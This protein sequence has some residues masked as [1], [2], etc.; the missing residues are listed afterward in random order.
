MPDLL[1]IFFWGAL[2]TGAVVEFLLPFRAVGA[3]CNRRWI[4]NFAL[5]GCSMLCGRWLL[6]LIVALAASQLDFGLLNRLRSPVLALLCGFLILD[7]LNYGLHRLSHQVPLLWRLHR[8]HHSD[9]DVD[10]STSFRHHPL[11]TAVTL[12]VISSAIIAFG[13]PP[14][15]V[16]AHR[17]GRA[18]TDVFSHLN[19]ALPPRLDRLLRLVIITPAMHRIHHSSRQVETDSNYSTLLSLWDR[20]F[21]SYRAAPGDDPRVMPLGL[22]EWRDERDLSLPRLLVQPFTTPAPAPPPAA[23]LARKL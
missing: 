4:A 11:E 1:D 8:V 18:V 7:G 5:G 23:P 13:I 21:G 17:L 12:A 22:E 9:L 14:Y 2:V 10:V 16:L 20:L 15:A 3:A 6:P 19:I